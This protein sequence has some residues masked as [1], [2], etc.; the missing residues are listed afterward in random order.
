MGCD[1]HPILEVKRD[2]HWWQLTD[3]P[4]YL[5]NRNYFVFGMLTGGRVRYGKGQKLFPEPRGYPSDNI[6]K[7]GGWSRYDELE[8][9]P[10]RHSASWVTLRELAEAAYNEET[11]KQL[12]AGW[13]VMLDELQAFGALDAVRIV[14]DFD[15]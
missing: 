10:D 14:F 3:E 9:D 13:F 11:R 4:A 6:R 8:E 2:G 12:G 5:R 7:R 15:N 1:I